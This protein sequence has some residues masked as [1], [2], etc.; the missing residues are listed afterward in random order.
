M[1]NVDEQHFRRRR[2]AGAAEFGV[3]FKQQAP[4]N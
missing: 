2:E 3:Q 4:A 1:L